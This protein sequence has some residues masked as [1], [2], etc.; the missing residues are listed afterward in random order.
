MGEE[1]GE[2]AMSKENCYEQFNVSA[3]D[4]E[5]TKRTIESKTF[6]APSC[7]PFY[8]QMHDR[9]KHLARELDSK[10]QE[11]AALQAEVESLRRLLENKR[12]QDYIEIQAKI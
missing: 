9:A 6:R 10:V 8:I 7:Y 2:G 11:N 3:L 1:D 12:K 4:D 5:L